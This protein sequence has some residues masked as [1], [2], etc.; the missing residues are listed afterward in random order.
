[1]LD[2]CDTNRMRQAQSTATK[3]HTHTKILHITQTHSKRDGGEHQDPALDCRQTWR[4]HSGWWLPHAPRVGHVRRRWA[5]G[6]QVGNHRD[7]C[8]CGCC[9]LKHAAS[10]NSA[11][12]RTRA[13]R[14]GTSLQQRLV[15]RLGWSEERYHACD[16]TPQAIEACLLA[17]GVYPSQLARP[18]TCPCPWAHNCNLMCGANVHGRCCL[19]KAQV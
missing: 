9:P 15:R 19:T 17:K 10:C 11:K 18:H 16:F 3:S 14:A 6:R 8:R 1:M 13:A 2:A 12:S 7:Q 5:D 4:Q